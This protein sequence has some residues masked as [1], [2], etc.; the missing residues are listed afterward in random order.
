[1]AG[2]FLAKLN[3]HQ[4]PVIKNL[5]LI[6]REYNIGMCC[7]I[8]NKEK[9]RKTFIIEQKITDDVVYRKE[10]KINQNICPE[11]FRE[12]SVTR[13][14]GDRIAVVLE[15]YKEIVDEKFWAKSEIKREDILFM[16]EV[17]GILKQKGFLRSESTG[18]ELSIRA[19]KM[20][21][22]RNPKFIKIIKAPS[23][24]RLNLE[25]KPYITKLD[26]ESFLNA[27]ENRAGDNM[28]YVAKGKTNE[29][30]D[31]RILELFN[32]GYV[33]FRSDGEPK[34]GDNLT[35]KMKPCTKCGEI[36]SWSDF[37]E[38]KDGQRFNKCFDCC[39]K[40][41]E[42]YYEENCEDV[43]AYMR[44]YNKTPAGKASQKKYYKNNPAYRAIKN[45]RKKISKLLKSGQIR[46]SKTMGLNTCDF[47]KY[48]AGQFQIYGDWM[49]WDN[50]G[51]ETWHIDHI[52]PISVWDE[53][54]HLLPTYFEGMGPN[55]YTN[56]RPLES[57]ENVNRSNSVDP[58]EIEEH[59]RKIAEIFPDMD[60]GQQKV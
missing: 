6:G 12:D 15:P 30:S 14:K 27:Y 59:F 42:R 4:K 35:K 53:N 56:L 55:H 17:A 9:E 34:F 1:M 43:K 13:Q 24:K 11:C 10:I 5:K 25:N 22:L 37:Y 32:L 54:C 50:Y 40:Y 60:F 3:L 21:Q 19:K 33:I 26:F 51:A 20:I 49:S 2:L 38:K 23:F 7:I 29:L 31:D 47:K 58:K 36:K 28:R 18:S 44:E 8:C 45:Q 52:I 39:K 46:A 16:S 41:R 57:V 48:I